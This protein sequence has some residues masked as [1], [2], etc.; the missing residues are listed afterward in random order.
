M[1]GSGIMLSSG[2]VVMTTPSASFLAMKAVEPAAE[3]AVNV[4]SSETDTFVTSPVMLLAARIGPSSWKKIPLHAE[5]RF[6]PPG[7][8]TASS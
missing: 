3:V 5:L 4:L 2:F 6:E 1:V 8:S 7:L